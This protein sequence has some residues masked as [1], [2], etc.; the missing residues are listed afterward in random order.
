MFII[1]SLAVAAFGMWLGYLFYLKR[2]RLPDLWAQ[3][4]AALYRASYNKYWVD[5]LYGRL[6]T[7][8]TMDAARGVY[9]VDSKVIDGAVNGVAALTRRASSLTGMFDAKVVDGAVNG[10]AYFIR[11]IM[12]R[13][14]RSA[15]TG[16]T[17]N[18]AFVMVLGL[19]VA[20]V[21][22]FYADIWTGIRQLF[23]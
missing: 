16:V 7:R 12:S 10:V 11:G 13:L 14:F 6:V 4:L 1:I 17:A 5:E 9:K 8:R 22:F 21:M 15:Q 3:R 23:L 20:V 2:P 19:V 18:Y